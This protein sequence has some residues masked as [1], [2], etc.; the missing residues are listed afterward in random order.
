MPGCHSPITPADAVARVS[1]VG[2]HGG[3]GPGEPIAHVI[4]GEMEAHTTS[5]LVLYTGRGGLHYPS[6]GGQ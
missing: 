5:A 4:A 1:G 2:Q 6:C 3:R